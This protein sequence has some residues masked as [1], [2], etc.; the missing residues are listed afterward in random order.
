M[1]DSSYEKEND[2]ESKK[3]SNLLKQT[4]SYRRLSPKKVAQGLGINV[5]T[6]RKYINE[7]STANNFPAYKLP[8]F[9]KKVGD[10]VLL[11]LAAESGY[12][13]THLKFK[14]TDV[15]T[16]IQT[17]ARALRKF[18]LALSTFSKCV[19]FDFYNT[20]VMTYSINETISEL[21]NMLAIMNELK[22]KRGY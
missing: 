5:N 19:E 15:K 20:E 22:E 18:S 6:F 13:L 11:H 3:F 7:N 10:D 8:V 21:H 9:T 2:I 12:T 14:K 16:A 4:I 17:S 1:L